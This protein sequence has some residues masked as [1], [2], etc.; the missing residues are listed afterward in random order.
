MKKMNKC[1]DCEKVIKVAGNMR[2]NGKKGFIDW[3]GRKYHIQ[4]WKK[5]NVIY[6]AMCLCCSEERFAYAEKYNLKLI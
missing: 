1:F 2:K 4:C 3:T 5:I 6:Q